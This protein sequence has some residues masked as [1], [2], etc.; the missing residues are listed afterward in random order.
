M[1]LIDIVILLN[2]HSSPSDL[3][4]RVLDLKLYLITKHI[5]R[6]GGLQLT[7]M[8]GYVIV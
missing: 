5:T 7:Y 4:V 6:M 1:F 3:I 8:S 2:M